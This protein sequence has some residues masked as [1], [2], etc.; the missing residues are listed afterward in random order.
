MSGF[1][2]IH[3]AADGLLGLAYESLSRFQAPSVIL[4]LVAQG[5]VPEPVFGL[6]LTQSN[7]SE[8]FIGGVN[9]E[10]FKGSITYVPV[11][12]QVSTVARG[13]GASNMG[14][15]IDAIIQGFWQTSFDNVIVNGNRVLGNSSVI[16]D[17]G[18][19]IIFGDTNSVRTIYENIPGSAAIG[20]GRWACTISHAL[21]SEF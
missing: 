19:S 9:S 16:I 12:Q 20:G 1:D 4:S 3:A 2:I 8:L 5:Q 6:Y 14:P 18:T 17:S 13:R 21:L 11:E 15:N 10:H 7:D